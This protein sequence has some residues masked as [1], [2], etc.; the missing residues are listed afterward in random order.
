MSPLI[1]SLRINIA[2]RGSAAAGRNVGPQDAGA[3]SAVESKQVSARIQYG[4]GQR[5]HAVLLADL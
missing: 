1:A 4:N 2:R 5:Q 3:V